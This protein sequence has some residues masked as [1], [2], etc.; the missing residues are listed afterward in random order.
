MKTLTLGLLKHKKHGSNDVIDGMYVFQH[1]KIHG[2]LMQVIASTGLD[3]DHVSITL[4][5]ARNRKKVEFVKRCPTWED[6]CYAKDLFFEDHETVVQYHPA[7]SEYVN[8][9]PY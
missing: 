3:W 5:D 1:P 8:N 2:Y 6:M 4:V 9:H 7:K